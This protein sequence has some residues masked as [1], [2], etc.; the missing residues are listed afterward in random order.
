[1]S[2]GFIIFFTPKLLSANKYAKEQLIPLAK[3]ISIGKQGNLESQ[4]CNPSIQDLISSSDAPA[5]NRIPSSQLPLPALSARFCPLIPI[6]VYRSLHLILL[7]A[8]HCSCLHQQPLLQ[9]VRTMNPVPPHAS[10][11]LLQEC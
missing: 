4:Y 6:S 2:I 5:P 11:L 3:I 7:P 10:A 9:G 8:I 1:M